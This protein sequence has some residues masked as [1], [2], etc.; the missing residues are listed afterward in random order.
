MHSLDSNYW[1]IFD[2]ANEFFSPLSLPWASLNEN[3]HIGGIGGFNEQWFYGQ[4]DKCVHSPLPRECSRKK[5]GWDLNCAQW[6]YRVSWLKLLI[7]F[8]NKFLHTLNLFRRLISRKIRTFDVQRY[9]SSRAPAMRIKTSRH[10]LLT[11]R[12][13]RPP[14]SQKKGP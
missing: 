3:T 10:A 13:C 5:S 9:N 8:W 12:F 2:H 4:L 6:L 11:V 14:P 7:G 1:P